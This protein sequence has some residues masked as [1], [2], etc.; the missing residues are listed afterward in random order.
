MGAVTTLRI[1]DHREEACTRA[2]CADRH[3]R[4]HFATWELRLEEHG[5]LEREQRG[6]LSLYLDLHPRVRAVLGA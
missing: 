6:E 2:R 4:F 3:V 1:C 5:R